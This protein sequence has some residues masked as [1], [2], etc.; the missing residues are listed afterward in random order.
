MTTPGNLIC[1][2]CGYS[3][4]PGDQFCGSCGTFLEWDGVTA[5]TDPTTV[6]STD[7]GPY[8]GPPTTGTGPVTPTPT[9]VPVPPPAAALVR[10]PSCGIAN[11]ADRTFCQ[12]CGSKLSDAGRITSA[13]PEQIAVAVSQAGTGTVKARTAHDEP[14]DEGSGGRVKALI[15]LCVVGVLL[16]VGVIV[17]YSLLR[18]GAA[19]EAS[20][21]PTLAPPSGGA[22]AG[23]S[24]GSGEPSSGPTDEPTTSAEPPLSVALDIK[25]AKASSQAPNGNFPPTLAVDGDPTTPWKEGAKDEDGQWIDV[26][27]AKATVTAI[28]IS[29][30]NQGPPPGEYDRNQRLRKVVLTIG[31]QQFNWTLEDTPNEQRLTLDTPVEGATKVRLT[32]RT[33]YPSTA[34]G[35][36]ATDGTA[37]GEITVMGVTT[38]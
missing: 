30:G 18:G 17:G 4:V 6:G 36:K 11:A 9:P 3:N 12:S 7:P 16:G 34:T 10:C 38:P 25:T 8:P 5:E 32:I 37:L 31:K 13:T 35:G 14:E 2:K 1:S 29:N 22:T 26:T 23:P 24:D 27:F 33:V 20:A 28:L 21:K 19:S 15:G